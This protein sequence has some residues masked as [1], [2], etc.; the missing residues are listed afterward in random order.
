MS[1]TVYTSHIL[2]CLIT[3]FIMFI[4]NR[5]QPQDSKSKT[6][7]KESPKKETKSEQEIPLPVPAVKVSSEAAV[8][9][10]SVDDVES[11]PEATSSVGNDKLPEIKVVQPSPEMKTKLKLDEGEKEEVENPNK[12]MEEKVGGPG[13]KIEEIKQTG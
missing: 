11:T 6:E 1:I 4:G 8:V 10:S 12:I 2:S 5:K 7:S 3:W 9:A 13:D